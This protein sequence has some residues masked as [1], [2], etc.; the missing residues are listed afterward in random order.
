[1]Q[2]HIN[3]VMTKN[4]QTVTSAG[5]SLNQVP[6]LFKSAV[7]HLLAESNLYY[8][9]FDIGAGRYD[10]TFDYILSRFDGIQYM[11][12]DPYNRPY[13]ENEASEHLAEAVLE[14]EWSLIVTCS[15]VLNVLDSDAAI[16]KVCR[17]AAYYA[18]NGGIALFTVYEGDGTGKGKYTSKG[19]QRNQGASFYIPFILSLIH[20]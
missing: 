9:V 2:T 16:E 17:Q 13:I 3:E 19:Y 1:M 18:S 7:F 14:Y 12:Y 10:K 20:I 15:N 4:F 6:R 8:G 11:P 5:T